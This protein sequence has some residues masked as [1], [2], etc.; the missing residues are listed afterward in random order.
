[1]ERRFSVEAKSFS[2]SANTEKSILRLEEKRKGYGGYIS[3]GIQC[4]DWLADTVEEALV[5]R[6]KEDF[7][8]SF[9]DEVRV[10][11]VRKG[12]NKAGCFLE[13]VVFV[14]GGR[15][16][17][18]RL[19]EG[20]CGWGWRSFVDELRQLLVL[21]VAKKS[22]TVPVATPGVDGTPPS[23]S[24]ASTLAASLGGLN[25]GGALEIC[26]E[27]GRSFSLSGGAS[28]LEALWN[29]VKKFLA[30]LRVDVARVISIGLGLKT[31]GPRGLR[32]RVIVGRKLK[33]ISACG[34]S[35]RPRPL[36]AVLRARAFSGDDGVTGSRSGHGEVSSMKAQ[37]IMGVVVD[38]GSDA[39]ASASPTGM[40][41]VHSP[42]K[43][44]IRRL[45]DAVGSGSETGPVAAII[46]SPTGKKAIGHPSPA[47]GMLRRGFLLRQSTGSRPKGSD[48]AG[49]SVPEERMLSSDSP[50]QDSGPVLDPSM[51]LDPILDPDLVLDPD[52]V[53]G[54]DLVLDPEL[55]L[56]SS[57]SDP[58]SVKDSGSPTSLVSF[59]ADS[60]F[61][62]TTV[63]HDL[64]M[65]QLVPNLKPAES[66]G[67]FSGEGSAPK[68]DP[69]LDPVP[70]GGLSVEQR[71]DFN[72]VFLEMFPESASCSQG[73]DPN[74]PMEDGL[75]IPQWW[76][77]DWLRDQV[78]HDEAQ[79]AYL[80]DVEEE[81]RE[82]NKIATP[83]GAVEGSELMQ[84]ELMQ[85][86]IRALG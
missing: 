76:L 86:V 8:K 66:G 78:K 65:R 15:K 62:V 33:R 7:A 40:F 14:E 2:F 69:D 20:R 64:P 44:L 42:A 54:S 13:V 58:I 72:R 11:K 5:S 24:Y 63:A 27:Q 37:E 3:L 10:L 53:L 34:L 82:L 26:S 47:K 16:G 41:P 1:M 12:S 36:D 51:D 61:L 68:K 28:L 9:R 38:P 46:A 60:V 79:L 30:K 29:M 74:I 23:R 77:L 18:I 31:K 48:L 71:K 70:R 4:S 39:A 83:P 80:M 81:A 17:V 22:P 67:G 84:S 45:D 56:D 32:K 49:I 50:V 6:G 85:V 59:V 55:G 25:R 19:P 43:G 75:T 21:F 73:S 57:G 52:P 35:L